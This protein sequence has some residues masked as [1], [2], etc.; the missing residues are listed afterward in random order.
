ML[1]RRHGSA[2][3]SDARAVTASDS[4]RLRVAGILTGIGAGAAMI[5]PRFS[6]TRFATHAMSAN[7]KPRSPANGASENA[8]VA[9]ARRRDGPHQ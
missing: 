8:M 3:W 9:A 7:A 5:Q 6:T 4:I 2:S 1:R